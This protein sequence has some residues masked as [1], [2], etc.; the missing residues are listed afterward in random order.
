MGKWI[1]FLFLFL[2]SWF[3]YSS[4]PHFPI[5]PNKKPRG[6]RKF[7]NPRGLFS[8]TDGLPV[9][10][11]SSVGEAGERGAKGVNNQLTHLLSASASGGVRQPRRTQHTMSAF[12]PLYRPLSDF[13]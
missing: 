12:S 13:C 7:P 2:A 5:P 9:R 3:P 6:V 4:F 11:R 10:H 1:C 8:L